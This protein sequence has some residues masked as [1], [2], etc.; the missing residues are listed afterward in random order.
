MRKNIL[1]EIAK[2]W[3]QSDEFKR[4][5]GEYERVI[6]S[7]DWQFIKELLMGMQGIIVNDMLSKAFTKLDAT[8]K[9]VS[10]RAY[11]QTVQILNFLANP[12]GWMNKQKQWKEK[13]SDS[14]ANTAKK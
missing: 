4:G 12:L 10:Q 1:T 6:N 14:V 13:Y 2:W 9:D 7:K 8:E 11:Y 5:I 3:E